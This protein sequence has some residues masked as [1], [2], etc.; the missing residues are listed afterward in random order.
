MV[1]PTPIATAGNATYTAAQVM[2]GWINRD[3]GAAA[4][5]DTMPSASSLCNAIQ[6]CMV[7]TSFDF[8]LRNTSAGAFAVTL[9][10]GPGVTL[11]PTS[12]TV[13]Q[14]ST[15]TYTV[16]FTNV[17]AGQEAY[18]VYARGTGSF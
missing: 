10:A 18:T 14:S 6:G 4:R 3:C 1:I 15:R 8:E 16:I 13:A 12:T 11:N 17:T 2:S 5:T 9:A 7:N